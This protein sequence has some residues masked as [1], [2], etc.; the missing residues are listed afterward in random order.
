M[1]VSDPLSRSPSGQ[2]RARG[3]GLPLPGT[4]GPLN[5]IT[6]V[7]GVAVG[8]TTLSETHVRNAIDGATSG[9]VPEG[10]VGGGT[11]MICY[12]YKGGANTAK[13]PI[14]WNKRV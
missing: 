12:E 2:L 10:S 7:P 1:P 3:L 13:P 5:A 9:P 11:G 6:D 4:P 8:T 14:T